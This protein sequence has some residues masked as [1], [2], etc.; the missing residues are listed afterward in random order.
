MN[1][2]QKHTVL[3]LILICAISLGFKLY[4]VDFSVPV[5]SDN[6]AYTLYAIAHNNGDFTQPP[7][8][9]IGWSIFL[10][11]F[12]SFIDSDNFLDYSNLSRI[13]SISVAT[14]SIFLIYGVARKFFDERYSL[15][16]SCLFAFL[17]H[18]NYNSIMGLSEPIF[19]LAILASFYFIL[20]N[21]LKFVAIS[22]ILAGLVYWIRLNGLIVI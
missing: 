5:H 14:S 13:I 22:F 2:P 17:P 15:V 12:F 11:T 19:I 18:L 6:L 10:S 16:T 20:N 3:C 21:K 1:L 4:L 8:R 9:G 7:H